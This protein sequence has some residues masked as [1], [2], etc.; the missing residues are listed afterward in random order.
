MKYITYT[1]EKDVVVCHG[2]FS[3]IK[4]AENALQ[5]LTSSILASNSNYFAIKQ[6][7]NIINIYES[8]TIIYKGYIYNS[9]EKVDKFVMKLGITALFER[10]DHEPHYASSISLTSVP[11][12][13]LIEELKC[14]LA[15][16]NKSK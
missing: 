3:T 12:S 6:D 1:L 15:L 7:F 8:Q 9:E 13:A 4:D 10:E 11:Q 14:V 5:D 16:R 2:L